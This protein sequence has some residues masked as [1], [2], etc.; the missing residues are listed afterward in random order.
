MRRGVFT[1]TRV[2]AKNATAPQTLL[3]TAANPSNALATRDRRGLF[4]RARGVS[5]PGIFEANRTADDVDSGTA[6]TSGALVPM[7]TVS[8][9][10]LDPLPMTISTDGC[11]L[12]F[13]AG[14]A[15][16]RTLWMVARGL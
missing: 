15:N 10:Q 3:G 12:Y 1:V 9:A 4:L 2:G 7:T 5:F 11:R 6:F 13:V 8:D 16:A 14:A